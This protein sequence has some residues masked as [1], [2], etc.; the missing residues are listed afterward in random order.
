MNNANNQN[1]FNFVGGLNKEGL[2]KGLYGIRFL[3]KVLKS[4][5]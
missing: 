4:N 1:F 3:I 2:D 5:Y